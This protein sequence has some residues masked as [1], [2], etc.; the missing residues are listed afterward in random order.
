MTREEETAK[1]ERLIA[2]RDG[3]GGYAK[4]VAAMRERLKELQDG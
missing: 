1:L 4:N 2:L 3:L